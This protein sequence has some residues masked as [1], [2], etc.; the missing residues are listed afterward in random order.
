MPSRAKRDK[1][2][3]RALKQFTTGYVPKASLAGM[4]DLWVKVC[5][6][7]EAFI[8]ELHAEYKA[9][10]KGSVGRQRIMQ[11]VIQMKKAGDERDFDRSELGLVSDEE[12]ESMIDAAVLAAG[13]KVAANEGDGFDDGGYCI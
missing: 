1:T 6:G 3:A 12:L 7:E 2:V 11:L 9:A 10:A 4:F 8:K 5:G 13:N